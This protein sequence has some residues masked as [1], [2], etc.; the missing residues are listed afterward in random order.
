MKAKSEGEFCGS[1]TGRIDGRTAGIARLPLGMHG[2]SRSSAGRWRSRE[3]A[4][5]LQNAITALG[6]RLMASEAWLGR[7]LH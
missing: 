1:F 2:K 7:A 6:A 4:K 5:P 3:D